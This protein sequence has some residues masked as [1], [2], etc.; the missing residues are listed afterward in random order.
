MEDCCL[1]DIALLAAVRGVSGVVNH[2]VNE[3][4]LTKDDQTCAIFIHPNLSGLG[5]ELGLQSMH[6]IQN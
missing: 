1:F 6:G 2:V 3:L 5:P 4:Y